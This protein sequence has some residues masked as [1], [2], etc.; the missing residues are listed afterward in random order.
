MFLLEIPI[1][2]GYVRSG[3]S[4]KLRQMQRFAMLNM[5]NLRLWI[6]YL[7]CIGGDESWI[8]ILD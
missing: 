7:V 2:R 5:L 6:D 3:R 4:Y 1:F 8:Y